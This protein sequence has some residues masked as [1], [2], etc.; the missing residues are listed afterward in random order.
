MKIKLIVIFSLALFLSTEGF[1]QIE[2]YVKVNPDY[3]NY[4]INPLDT[5]VMLVDTTASYVKYKERI[6]LSDSHRY[7]N[8]PSAHGKTEFRVCIDGHYYDGTVDEDIAGMCLEKLFKGNRFVDLVYSEVKVKKSHLC[9]YKV[10]TS[11][12]M[13]SQKKYGVIRRSGFYPTSI[14]AGRHYMIFKSDIDDDSKDYVIMHS[15]FISCGEVAY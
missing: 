13:N 11:D 4:K 9:K 7:R 6:I 8:N 2:R 10:F 3:R 12:W 15:V 1:S 14:F 5:V